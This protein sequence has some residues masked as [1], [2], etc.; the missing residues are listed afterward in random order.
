[1]RSEPV[2][3]LFAE[4]AKLKAEAAY[5]G[6]RRAVLARLA[7]KLSTGLLDDAR[8]AFTEE[9]SRRGVHVITHR[10]RRKVA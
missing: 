7:Q 10:Q 4:L 9:L 6:L 1:M 5:V 2:V 8:I 3:E